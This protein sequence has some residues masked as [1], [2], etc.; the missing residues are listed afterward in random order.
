MD[1][2]V[3]GGEGFLGA[4]CCKALSEVGHA[5]V[6]FDRSADATQDVRDARAVSSALE[7]ADAV[8]HLAG[9]LGTSELFDS[10]H[11]AVDANVHGTLNVLQACERYGVR[12]VGITMPDVW[13]NVYQATKA[14]GRRLASAWCSYRGV[15]VTHVRAFNAYGRGQKVW[16]VQKIL[17][18]W[19]DGTQLVDLIHADDIAHVLV[20]ALT[21]PGEDEVIDAGTGQPK[22]VIDVAKLVLQVTGSVAGLEFLPMREGETCTQIIAQGD[23][24]D[25]LAEPPRYNEDR[26]IETVHW[27]RAVALDQAHVESSTGTPLVTER[28]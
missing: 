6:P 17:P 5:A 28:V 18:I 14:C 9:L 2:V 19:G 11:A 13:S 22:S 25:L 12:Y 1:V 15:P 10:P 20:D 8:I 26:L 4:Y 24:W 21:T 23:G 27:Y 7:S 3:T 16:G